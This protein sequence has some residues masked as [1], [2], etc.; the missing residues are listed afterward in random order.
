MSVNQKWSFWIDR[1]GTFTD[2]I[3]RTPEGKLLT[4]KILSES[5]HRRDSAVHGIKEILAA[6]NSSLAELG[7]LRMGTTIG[8]NALLTRQGA[9]T[10][11]VTS[12]GF[13]DCVRI[14]YQNRPDIFAL[15]ISL[16]EMLYQQVIEFD[17]RIDFSG[18]ILKEPDLEK[19]KSDLQAAFDAGTRSCAIAL[20]HGYK[21]PTHE[22][23]AA[24]VAKEIGFEQISVSHES[25][26]LMKLISRADTTLA[27]AYLTPLLH[28]YIEGLRRDLG[29][30]QLH[31]MQSNG[32]LAAASL[33][34]GKD[35]ILSGPAGG[36]VGAIK[37]A[38]SAGFDKLVSFDMGG[39][40][41]DVSHFHGEI[42]HIYDTEISGMRIRA[43]MMDIHTVAAGG[44][45]VLGFD[46]TR[47][48]VGPDSAGA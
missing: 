18:K 47:L 46:G 16:P 44:G 39:T 11:F 12:K 8:T 7:Q 48:R 4:R 10:A 43:P 41:T 33:F 23:L 29:N 31:F 42:E 40:S 2:V 38:E 30:L 34:K 32:G 36:L 27:D 15:E 6:N 28:S 21:Y 5:S 25:A 19:L 14:A 9:K 35:S 22:I 1:G 17:E 26:P 45:S 13:A 20:M 24:K 37:A 3:A